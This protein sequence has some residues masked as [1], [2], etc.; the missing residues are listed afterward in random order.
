MFSQPRVNKPAV[1][2][3]SPAKGTRVKPGQQVE[4]KGVLVDL[5]L[6]IMIR[7]LND[8][9]G[10]NRVSQNSG[11]LRPRMVITNSAGKQVAEGV[12][13]FG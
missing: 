10:R 8:T 5:V 2:L 12:M 11:S 7:R 9:T 6:D 3:P 1:L 4:V 13:P